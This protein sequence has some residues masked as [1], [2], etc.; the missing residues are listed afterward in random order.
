MNPEPKDA[1]DREIDLVLASVAAEEPRRV[2]AASVRRAMGARRAASLPTWLA[3]AAILII[4]IGVVLKR[5]TPAEKAPEVIA[6]SG[7]APVIAEARPVP[8]IEPEPA[9]PTNEARPRPRRIPRTDTAAEAPY[10]GLPRLIVAAIDLPEPLSTG[11]LAG[12]S[13]LIPQI[14]ISPLVVSSLPN[15]HEPRQ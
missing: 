2:N 13:I 11:L 7:V 6:R 14:E 9:V 8:S 12:E 4:A 5:P 3:V 10:E 15:E 1:L